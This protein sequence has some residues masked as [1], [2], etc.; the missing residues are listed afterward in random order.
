MRPRLLIRPEAQA[1][2]EEAALW[3]EAQRPG[4]GD[5]FSSSVSDL[6]DRVAINPLHF[7]VAIRPVRRGL[8]DRFPYAVYYVVEEGTVVIVAVVHQ[9]RDPE[10]WR[11]RL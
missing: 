9:R 3:Y 10:V 8:L 4:L 6:I 5:T 2:L 1:D 7:P 11:R